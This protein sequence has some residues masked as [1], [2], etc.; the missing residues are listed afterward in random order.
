MP[1]DFSQLAASLVR[2]LQANQAAGQQQQ[3]INQGQQQLG[4]QTKQ[5]GLEQQKEKL[6]EELSA[7]TVDSW[8]AY[9]AYA[10]SLPPQQRME[11]YRDIIVPGAMKLQ[12][13]Q[14]GVEQLRQDLTQTLSDAIGSAKP[15]DAKVLA[16]L[17]AQVQGAPDL[18][19]LRQLENKANGI[20]AGEAKPPPAIQMLPVPGGYMPVTRSG[21]GYSYGLPPAAGSA[22]S[23]SGGSPT[24]P[25][26]GAGG[27]IRK[28]TTTETQQADAVQQAL[29][30]IDAL[31][32]EIDAYATETGPEPTGTLG[33]LG[34]AAGRAGEYYGSYK[35]L[36]STSPHSVAFTDASQLYAQIAGALMRGGTRSIRYLQQLSPHIPKATDSPQLLQEKIGKWRDILQRE[37]EELNRGPWAGG[38]AAAGG[39]SEGSPSPPRPAA[40]PE[41]GVP[42]Y[43]PNGRVVGHSFDGGKTMIPVD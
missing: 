31:R 29:D 37:K 43:A 22:P 40:T 18:V 17:I 7:P 8:K 27:V 38:P 41:A 33:K 36:G 19:T 14:Q 21:A 3:Q 26:E 5:L 42:M 13:A 30:Q 16:A 1:V 20:L 23:A 39:G 2:T 6:N 15:E 32:P 34:A 11:A 25:G 35:M 9:K 28:P 4:I 10:D 24:L 12:A